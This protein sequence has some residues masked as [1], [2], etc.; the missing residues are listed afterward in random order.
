VLRL[1][2]VVLL[3]SELIV[4][5]IVSSSR[6]IDLDNKPPTQRRFLTY[7]GECKNITIAYIQVLL[8]ST[9]YKT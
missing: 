2:P 4:F 5:L 7:K 6:L 1:D 9:T 3:W 8:M